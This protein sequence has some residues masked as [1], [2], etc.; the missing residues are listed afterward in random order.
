MLWASLGLALLSAAAPSLALSETRLTRHYLQKRT[1]YPNPGTV[2]GATT[3]VHDPSLVKTPGGTYILY[4]TGVGIPIWT[5]TDRTKWVSAGKAFSTA[6][7]ATDTFTGASD[8]SLWAPDVTYVDG[9]YIMYYSASSFGSSHSGI[10]MAQ[11]T[12]G[13]A[14]SWTDEGLVTSTT[15]SSGY[16]AI[17]PHLIVTSAGG[18]YLSLGSF[19]SGIKVMT[20]S[21]ST[22]KTASSTVT[23]I[24]ERTADGGAEEGSW[25]YHTGS[26]YYLFTSWD[27]CCDGTSST[28]NIRVTRSK[29]LTGPY[30]DKSGVAALSGGG[31]EILGTHG[32]IYGPGG[33]SILL[34]GDDA[35]LVYHYYSA[36]TSLLGINLLDFST[37]WP[38]VY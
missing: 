20:L 7:S 16:N 12:T 36:T 18:W 24:S 9:K 29:K 32:T 4:G 33:Q 19:W 17:D 8:A 10:F 35:V 6:P 2:T 25:I 15:T 34:D 11:S 1:T 31:T 38:V 5:S 3:G 22:G 37:G 13:L 14:G 27:K 21:S 30:V 23:S 26:Y 28:Y